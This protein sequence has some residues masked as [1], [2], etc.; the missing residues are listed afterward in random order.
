MQ[1]AL[2]EIPIAPS[3]STPD[4]GPMP[5]APSREGR[6][7]LWR[8]VQSRGHAR[9]VRALLEA[10]ERR[11]DRS[12]TAPGRRL[13]SALDS[14]LAP[15]DGADDWARLALACLLRLSLREC[16]RLPEARLRPDVLRRWP[17]L[18]APVDI[19][20][21]AWR[22]EDA[23]LAQSRRDRAVL[24]WPQV[25]AAVDALIDAQVARDLGCMNR[26]SGRRG[27]IGT[28]HRANLAEELRRTYRWRVLGI[29]AR[30]DAFRKILRE[31]ATPLQGWW[32]E[33]AL[34][35]FCSGAWGHVPTSTGPCLI[36]ARPTSSRLQT[37]RTAGRP[38]AMALRDIV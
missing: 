10:C 22:I 29:G 27:R 17:E 9:V 26:A 2:L 14:A 15:V 37:A 8:R 28:A 36:D 4:V 11:T 24:G 35:P 6:I 19:A 12:A 31:V 23:R 20:V 1:M 16:S 38:S 3:D 5:L 34:V 33:R 30:S 32:M 21:R 18:A 7:H 25:I 13:H